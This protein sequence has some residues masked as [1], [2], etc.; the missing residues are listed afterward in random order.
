MGPQTQWHLLLLT[1][2]KHNVTLPLTPP[3]H[4]QACCMGLGAW[5]CM[6]GFGCLG[7]YPPGPARDFTKSEKGRKEGP[8]KLKALES[9]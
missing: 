4:D 1:L 6:M 5:L 9:A 7:M 3:Y 8:S 2:L